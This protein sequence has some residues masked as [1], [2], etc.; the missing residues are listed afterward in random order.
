MSATLARRKVT[1]GQAFVLTTVDRAVDLAV[2]CGRLRGGML[3]NG[4][5]QIRMNCIDESRR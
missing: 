1:Q 3:C 5:S 2:G 4:D